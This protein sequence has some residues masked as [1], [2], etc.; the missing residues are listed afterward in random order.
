[1]AK[2]SLIKIVFMLLL[3]IT[4]RSNAED[5]NQSLVDFILSN[6]PTVDIYDRVKELV[7]QGAD[8]NKTGG[9]LEQTPLMIFAQ[10]YS[11]YMPMPYGGVRVGNSGL[12]NELANKPGI[13]VNAQDKKGKTALIYLVE[14]NPPGAKYYS[15]MGIIDSI[16]NLLSKGADLRIKDHEGKTALDYAQDDKVKKYLLETES[17]NKDYYSQ[18]R[19]ANSMK[20]FGASYGSV[21]LIIVNTLISRKV[22]LNIPFGELKQTVL[23]PVAQSYWVEYR[24]PCTAHGKCDPWRNQRMLPKVLD[25]PGIDVNIQDANGKT[26]LMYLVE[27][28]PEQTDRDVIKPIQMLLDK[29]AYIT[30]QDNEG[31]AAVDYAKNKKVK[32]YLLEKSALQNTDQSGQGKTV[33]GSEREQFERKITSLQEEIELLKEKLKAIER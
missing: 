4:M 25:V 15:S 6:E 14:N 17:G 31:K 2:N 11:I 32:N 28:T 13:D 3:F 16:Q 7:A 29:G 21:N 22:N 8:V 26:A 33:S 24:E 27:A 12:F 23:M 20:R 10:R 9:P 5:S 18:I 1:M 19:I 30:L